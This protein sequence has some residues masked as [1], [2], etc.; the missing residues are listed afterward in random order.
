[1]VKFDDKK[2]QSQISQ[3][4]NDNNEDIAG[5]NTTSR[6]RKSLNFD[7]LLEEINSHKLS[8]VVGKFVRLQSEGG[9]RK[10]GKCPFHH[11]R[12]PSF[13]IDDNKGVFHCFGCG[14]G[15]GGA[16]S[17]IQKI[18]H[19]EFKQ[20]LDYL[21]D[22][23]SINKDKYFVFSET[24]QQEVEKKKTFYQAMLTVSDF[25]KD[26]LRYDEEAMDY[27]TKIRDLKAETLREF[28]FG[29][30]KGSINQL[31]QYCKE[32]DID[33]RMLQQCGIVRTRDSLVHGGNSDLEYLFFRDRIMIPIHDSQG[34]IVAF[35]GRVYKSGDDGA[36]YINSS[37]NKYFKK[38]DILFNFNRAKK[39]LNK[40]KQLIIVEGYMDVV[41][42]WQ[43]DF[44][45]AIAPLG[46]SITESHLRTIFSYCKTPIFM[47]DSDVAGQKASLRVCAMI[48]PMLQTGIIPRF[49][50]LQNA[51]DVDEYLKK[52]SSTKLQEQLDS[53][54][55]INNFI[56]DVKM[57]NCDISN[58]NAISV[59]Q[60]ELENFNSRIPDKILRS[61]YQDF[62]RNEFYKL[63]TKNN[64]S[65]SGASKRFAI[66]SPMPSKGS[67][68][69]DC[70]EK[71][72]IAF[73]LFYK[74]F[75]NKEDFEEMVNS[76]LSTNSQNL[77]NEMLEKNERNIRLF[78]DRYMDMK[79]INILDSV[80]TIYDNN[81]AKV[82][83][84]KRI[85]MALDALILCLEE[86]KMKN[87]KMSN[88]LKRK[89]RKKIL[90]KKKRYLALYS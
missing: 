54:L 60:K 82:H 5:K 58:A 52:Y 24:A 40:E 45:T 62:F 17:F 46:T 49:C 31:K 48:A 47:F 64:Y 79:Y 11:E 21:C 83:L 34:K 65:K 27:L 36:K 57:R 4:T 53:A 81:E 37:E 68:S 72:I 6:R 10:K 84:N 33:D 26:N 1:M 75:L 50:V 77:L 80:K 28:S 13:H 19:C 70:L 41:M 42:L 71:K 8:D 29:L 9:G 23:F 18:N 55:A 43:N 25:Y 20:A 38:G 63:R 73:I 85:T 35:G 78:C 74:K 88:S 66:N 90:E 32:R 16:I 30:A 39:R 7:A 56:F 2:T 87:S 15:G 67:N 3:N 14:E 89:E 61:N 51:K 22:F 44:D 86:T 69:I 12:T 59:I 76:H